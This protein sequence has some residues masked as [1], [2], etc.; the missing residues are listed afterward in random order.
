M[1]CSAMHVNRSLEP[2]WAI[3]RACHLAQC[4]PATLIK[5][6][7][8]LHAA[9]VA[10]HCPCSRCTP[11][12]RTKHCL[13]A[14]TAVFLHLH[15]QVSPSCCLPGQQGSSG[16][17]RNFPALPHNTQQLHRPAVLTW[18]QRQYVRSMCIRIWLSEAF[19][20]Q[21]MPAACCACCIVCSICLCAASLHQVVMSLLNGEWRSNADI[22][23]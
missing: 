11:A 14:L 23:P 1:R 7:A 8:L 10:P 20:V 12:T 15:T 13:R 3:S 9:Y 22:I 17:L 19:H 5:T 21:G 2:A 6:T 18:I 4:M 16:S